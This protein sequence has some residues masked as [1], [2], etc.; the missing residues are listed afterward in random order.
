M[1]I[2][3]LLVGGL[4]FLLLLVFWPHDCQR[5]TG[6]MSSNSTAFLAVRPSS[7]TESANRDVDNGL[8]IICLSRNT[9]MNSPHPEV[10]DKLVL[11]NLRVVEY[12]LAEREHVVVT[13]RLNGTL[14][15]RKPPGQADGMY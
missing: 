4:V 9:L 3:L 1:S 15:N 14:V 5:H 7:E 8:T 11:V 10:V 13:R 12:D 6:E 2:P